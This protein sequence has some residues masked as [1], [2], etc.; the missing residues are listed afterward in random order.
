MRAQAGKCGHLIGA[1]RLRLLF[2]FQEESSSHVTLSSALLTHE[3]ERAI[4]GMGKHRDTQFRLLAC[5]KAAKL[6]W[7][8]GK[9]IHHYCS[10]TCAQPVTG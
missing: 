7:P 6:V 9:A 8:H 4:I 5:A 1:D 10:D 2:P 3:T